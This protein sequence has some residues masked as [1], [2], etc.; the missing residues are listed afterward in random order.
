MSPVGGAT[1]GLGQISTEYLCSKE[2][3]RL[4]VGHAVVQPNDLSS[5]PRI[6][7]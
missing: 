2:S 7:R 4:V 6:D 5:I 1:R 3:L